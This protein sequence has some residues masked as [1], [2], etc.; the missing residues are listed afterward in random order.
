[1][2]AVIR[3]DANNI[4]GTGHIMRCLTLCEGLKIKNFYIRFVCRGLPKYLKKIILNKGFDIAELKNKSSKN[5]IKGDLKH[6]KWLNTTQR[7]D[8][9]ET[10]DV[11]SDRFWDLIIVDHYALDFRW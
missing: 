6:S 7:L 9:N 5:N 8:A 10:I 11:I 2:Y 4:I 3:S 1:M